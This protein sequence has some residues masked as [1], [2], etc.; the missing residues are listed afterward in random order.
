MEFDKSKV[1]TALNADELKPGSKV[2]LADD[3]ESLEYLVR[4]N[5]TGIELKH[6]SNASK[7]RRF[8]NNDSSFALAYLVSEPASL[9]WTDLKIGDVIEFNVNHV[10]FM[11]TGIDKCERDSVPHLYYAGDWQDDDLLKQ[12]HKVVTNEN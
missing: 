4:N 6:I 7:M 2:L 10:Q 3:L 8:C 11:I 12:Y 1:Y 9:K 5:Y